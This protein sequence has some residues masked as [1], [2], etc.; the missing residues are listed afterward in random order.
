MIKSK[1][2]SIKIWAEQDEHLPVSFAVV[3]RFFKLAMI[4]SDAGGGAFR[5]HSAKDELKK[6]PSKI[7]LRN[8][9]YL[10]A[11]SNNCVITSSSPFCV[12]T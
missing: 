4:S 1:I 2:A 8:W 10:V 9:T 11:C 5:L 6:C 3:L 7:D 12:K